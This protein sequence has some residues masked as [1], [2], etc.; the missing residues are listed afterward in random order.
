MNILNYHFRYHTEVRQIFF[1]RM[2]DSTVNLAALGRFMLYGGLFE[3]TVLTCHTSRGTFPTV[4]S[5]YQESESLGRQVR[6][7]LS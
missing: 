7:S 3:M 5:I 1:I 6:R 2:C 4:D